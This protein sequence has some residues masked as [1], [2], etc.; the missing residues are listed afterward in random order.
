MPRRSLFVPRRMVEATPNQL[1]ATGASGAYGLD[2]VD[3]DSGY[4]QVGAGRREQPIW[5]TERSRSY[6]VAA[7]RSN[8]M[9]RAIIDTYVSFVVGDSGLTYQVSNA[10]V[11]EVVRQFWTDPRNNIGGIQ[12]ALLRDHM[13]MGETALELLV[14]G[15]SGATRISPIDVSR[16]TGVELDRG[17]PLWPSRLL[18]GND[19]AL[20]V[21][22]IDDLTGLR[23]GQV[24]FF[25]SWRALITDRR[26]AP[27]LS[28]ILDQL[29]AYDQVLNNL[30]DRTALARYLVW[31][32]TIDGGQTDVD[33]FVRGRG[34]LHVPP[35]GT[36][37]VHNSSVKW[38]PK[39][40]QT[41][42]FE[43][44]NTLSSILTNVAGGAGLAKTWISDPE[45]ANRATSLTMAEPVRRRI[46]G[47]QNTWIGYMT[48]LARFAVDQA[49]AAGRIP[50]MVES[51]DT[52]TGTVQ[53][54]RAADTVTLAGPEI[55][56]ADAQVTANV[57]L[58]LAQAL[59]GLTTA[60]VL[61]KEA[62]AI[63]AEK[64][65]EQFV[66]LPFRKDLAVDPNATQAQVEQ[67]VQEA[68]TIRRVV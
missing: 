7:Y 28:P 20:D 50:A 67:I 66:G 43:D 48:E 58:N 2:P 37:E 54:V 29:D 53:M 3:N 19:Q 65:W 18:I 27:F 62:G 15:I 31:D 4:T 8:P 30:I 55:A 39:T 36:V 46:G 26:G 13:L 5:T 40:A 11:A 52:A 56:D 14:G 60:G 61:S 12:E 68:S 57:M 41:G 51:S 1:V 38:E 47:V 23:A 10:E 42:S 34:G 21:A 6:S 59:D 35:S 33:D 9:A 44:T 49:V 63:A 22:R 45:G 25:A 24:L 32:V 17:N 16:V 64:A